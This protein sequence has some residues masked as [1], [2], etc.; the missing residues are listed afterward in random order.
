[1]GPSVGITSCVRLTLLRNIR[2]KLPPPH[3]EKGNEMMVGDLWADIAQEDFCLQSNASS[4]TGRL[5]L[6]CSMHWNSPIF[7]GLAAVPTCLKHPHHSACLVSQT[8]GLSKL[9]ME[10]KELVELVVWVFVRIS[11]GLPGSLIAS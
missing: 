6:E 11:S 3:F 2:V 7:G 5:S 10:P 4:G 8:L 1:M 9:F